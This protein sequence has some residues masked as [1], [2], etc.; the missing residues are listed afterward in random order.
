MLWNFHFII[1]QW[2]NIEKVLLIVKNETFDEMI[3]LLKKLHQSLFGCLNI[4][5]GSIATYIE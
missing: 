5:N 2:N 1:L 4:T 3:V